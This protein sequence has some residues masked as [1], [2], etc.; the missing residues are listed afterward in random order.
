M[1]IGLFR[2]GVSKKRLTELKEQ[3]NLSRSLNFDSTTN[4]HDVAGLI[5]EFLRELP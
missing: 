4:V 5:K 1:T 3:V 2:V